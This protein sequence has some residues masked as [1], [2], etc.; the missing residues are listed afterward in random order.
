MS[1]AKRN[2][3]H[4]DH[5]HH[6]SILKL[7]MCLS[8]TLCVSRQVLPV[9]LEALLLYIPHITSDIPWD[10]KQV[11]VEGCSKTSIQ[12]FVHLSSAHTF[13]PWTSCLYSLFFPVIPQQQLFWVYQCPAVCPSLYRLGIAGV[14]CATQVT[15]VLNFY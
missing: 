9:V 14:S 11:W 10:G 4:K 15:C 6:L 1:L 8:V 12:L 7:S 13:I 2:F 5:F 3:T